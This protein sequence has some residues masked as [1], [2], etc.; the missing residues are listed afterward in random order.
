MRSFADKLN[1]SRQMEVGSWIKQNLSDGTT[2]GYVYAPTKD[3]VKVIAI[4]EYGGSITGQAA[5][6][7]TKGWNPAPVNIEAK[8]VPAKA[9]QKIKAK[10]QKLNVDVN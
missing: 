7:T 8:D 6:K 9:I 1:E 4:T 2:Y 3:A 10:A 5:S